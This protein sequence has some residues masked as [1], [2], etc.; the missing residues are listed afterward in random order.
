M[1]AYGDE[2]QDGVK[3]VEHA[4]CSFLIR[5]G[6]VTLHLLLETDG[7]ANEAADEELLQADTAHVYV[8]TWEGVN[9]WS[10]WICR[11]PTLSTSENLALGNITPR[12]HAS[13][14]GLDDEREDVEKYEIKAESPRFEPQDLG[15]RG[16][17][18]HHPAQ[19]HVSVCVDPEG[20]KLSVH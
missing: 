17:I 2:C 18:V 15:A 3:D 8:E 20:C 12:G 5:G 19:D 11:L 6:S 16:E 4:Q 10:A 1:C 9:E 13:S 14:Y 7:Q